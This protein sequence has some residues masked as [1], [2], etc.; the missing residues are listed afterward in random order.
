MARC[1]FA[2]WRGPA[3]SNYRVGGVV[4]PVYGVVMHVIVGSLAAADSV[5]HRS[6][7]G[8]S[9]HFGIGKDGT[10]FQW[11]D[12]DDRAW[13]EGAG[14]PYWVSVE[15]EGQPSEPLTNAQAAAFARLFVWVNQAHGPFPFAVTDSPNGRGLGTHQ[16]GGGAWGGHACP[17]G[18][19]AAQRQLVIDL[20]RGS[21]PTPPQEED[22]AHSWVVKIGPGE[23][24]PI[25]IPPPEE[26]IVAGRMCFASVAWDTFDRAGM[27]ARVVAGRP[28]G[29]YAPW[30]GGAEVPMGGFGRGL[31]WRLRKRDE[32]VSI[33]NRS[34][35]WDAAHPERGPNLTFMFEAA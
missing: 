20:A 23:A 8:A 18:P 7:Y 27:S 1:P 33:I 13:A 26:G 35:P 2:A 15:T 29:L 5:F 22:M 16:M 25:A 3:D 14:N 12:T 31:Q 19:R 11:V 34:A 17:G 24:L 6:G 28:G 30:S 10:T 9:A 4:R 32:V 21:G